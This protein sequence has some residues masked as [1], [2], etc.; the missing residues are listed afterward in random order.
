MA[1]TEWQERSEIVCRKCD[2]SGTVSYRLVE[3]SEGHEDAQYRCQCGGSW[4]IVAYDIDGID[5]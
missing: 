1:S 2:S 5:S 4:W 3:D